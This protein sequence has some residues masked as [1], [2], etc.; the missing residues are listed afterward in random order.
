MW[1]LF[2]V[3]VKYEKIWLEIGRIT[4]YMVLWLR[5]LT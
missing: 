5:I 3:V 2:S 1:I 4:I